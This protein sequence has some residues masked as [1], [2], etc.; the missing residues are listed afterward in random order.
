MF[1]AKKNT[2]KALTLYS[3]LTLTLVTKVFQQINGKRKLKVKIRGEPLPSGW[4][5][6]GGAP[7]LVWEPGS[8]LRCCSRCWLE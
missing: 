4:D 8:S 5:A 2:E 3:V 6:A 1:P 7:S